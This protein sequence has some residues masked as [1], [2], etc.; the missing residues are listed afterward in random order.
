L[1]ESLRNFL[2]EYIDYLAYKI[3]TKRELKEPFDKLQG[4]IWQ[5]MSDTKI[6]EYNSKI[7]DLLN[8]EKHGEALKL[9]EKML[10][11][12]P[13]SEKDIKMKQASVLRNMQE[14]EAG[15]DIINGLIQK[16]P[17]DNNLISYQA[18]WLQYLNRKEEAIDLM[19]N[20]IDLEPDNDNDAFHDTYGE[21]LMYFEEYETAVKVFQ[22]AIDKVPDAQTYIK[23]GVCH[24]ELNNLA[25]ATEN[26][27]TGK[28]LINNSEIDQESKQKWLTI[29]NLFLA[30]IE[31]LG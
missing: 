27:E 20:L 18:Y 25:L 15:L 3:E 23:L 2:P 30:E 9:L 1:K 16:Y 10:K 5:R 29:A 7:R 11:L 4:I 8:L 26:L 17:E 13:A 12:F 22:T 14:V 28:E 19:Q 24:K 21:I 6:E 31:E